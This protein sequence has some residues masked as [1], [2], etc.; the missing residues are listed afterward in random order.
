MS[1]VSTTWP[2]TVVM[3]AAGLA[4]HAPRARAQDDRRGETADSIERRVKRQRQGAGLRVGA[5]RVTGLTEVSG[6]EYSTTP[7]FEGY[8][9]RGLDRHLV[10]ETSAGFWRR[11]QRAGSGTGSESIG[12]Y[13]IPLLTALKLYPATGP[14]QNLEPFVTAGVGFTLGVDDRNTISGG[15]LGGGGSS[16]AMIAGVGIKGGGGVE[17]RLGRAFGFSAL[18]GYQYVRFFEQVGSTRSYKGLTAM[19]G[20][21]YRFQY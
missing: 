10:I 8:F 9:Q 15:L 4:V 12:S 11:S 2:I 21:T 20:L 13:V 6:A 14:E 16:T 17:Y 5:W 1:R 3:L 18:A 7:A 19:G